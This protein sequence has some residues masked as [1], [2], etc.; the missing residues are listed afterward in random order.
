MNHSDEILWTGKPEVKPNIWGFRDDKLGLNLS[1][2]AYF[3]VA[4]SMFT[5]FVFGVI[6]LLVGGVL[7]LNFS[8]ALS[9]IYVIALSCFLIYWFFI[10]EL[11]YYQLVKSTNYLI[12]AEAVM[13]KQKFLGREH[14]VTI[15]LTQIEHVHV[16]QFENEYINNGTIYLYTKP[17]INAYDLVRKERTNLPK[18]EHIRDFQKVKN[19]LKTLRLKR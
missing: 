3:G 7:L 9:A 6:A 11:K 5:S 19:I 4:P 15:D 13:I 10:R 18:L 12:T 2:T 16:V 1:D 8:L 14:F 17:D